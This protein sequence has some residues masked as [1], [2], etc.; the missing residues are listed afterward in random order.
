MKADCKKTSFVIH[1]R[2][3]SSDREFNLR[4]IVKFL[5]DK[6]DFHKLI[7]INDGIS[8]SPELKDIK[9]TYNDISILFME[10]D[11]E[12]RKALGFNEA[13]KFCDSE[14]IAFYDVD[15]LIDPKFLEETQ[16]LICEGIYDHVYPFNG[17]FINVLKENFESF[18]DDCNFHFLLENINRF[19]LASQNSPGG[20]NLISKKAFD[21][22]GGYDTRFIG[23]GFEDTDFYE[24]S[25][26]INKVSYL[27][28]MDSICWH[29]DHSSAI[30]VENPHYNDNLKLFI[31]NNR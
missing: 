18:I 23:W 6:V 28:G 16:K 21:K 30:R 24:R 31:K 26:R 8:L 4:T 20:C 22:I 29:L 15:V 9:K 12:F 1:Y 3:D 7:I 27:D 5:Y 13:S 10:N 25:C 2:R 17:T 19:E 14:V 11:D